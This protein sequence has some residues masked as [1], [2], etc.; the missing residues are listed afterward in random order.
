MCKHKPGALDVYS[1]TRV[2]C[3]IRE[4]YHRKLAVLASSGTFE[5]PFSSSPSLAARRPSSSTAANS[6]SVLLFRDAYISSF[7]LHLVRQ[8]DDDVDLSYYRNRWNIPA[9]FPN[10][11]LLVPRRMFSPERTYLPCVQQPVGYFGLFA[12]GSVFTR[13]HFATSNR[14]FP[15][16]LNS[17]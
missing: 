11:S 6:G 5:S 9:L 8:N 4:I 2:S 14:K 7:E 3:P 12:D 1:V 16:A 17:S 15:A 10:A 13:N